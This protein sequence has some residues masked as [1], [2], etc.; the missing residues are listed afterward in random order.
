MQ[1]I[2]C[3]VWLFMVFGIF[4]LEYLKIFVRIS[5]RDLYWILY[6]QI[7]VNKKHPLY[8]HKEDVFSISYYLQFC[9]YIAFQRDFVLQPVYQQAAF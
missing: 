3:C 7:K 1:K 9:I 5:V 8:I 6:I 4:L 2:L